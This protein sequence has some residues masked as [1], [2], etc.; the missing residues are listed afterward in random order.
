M[1]KAGTNGG[2]DENLRGVDL[3]F[4]NVKVIEFCNVAAGPYC[5]MLLADMGADVVKVESPAGDTLRQW[6]PIQD[7]MSANFVSLNRNKRSIALD[8]KRPEDLVVARRLIAGADIVLENNRPGAMARLGLGYDSFAADHPTLIYCSLSAYG[9]EGP[10]AN[11]G[12]FDVTVQAISG[13]MSVTGDLDGD[14]VKCGVPVSDF[15]TGLYGAFA[16][17]SLLARVRAGGRGGH[18]DVSML[19]SSLG[20]SALQTSEFFASGLNPRRMGA[21]HPRNA[22]YQA[23]KAS[24]GSFVL[25]A[26]ND[27]LWRAVCKVINR[28][29]L[30]DLPA[31]CTTT[32]RARNQTELATILNAIFAHR[33]IE[34]LISAFSGAGVP[35]TRV[36]SFEEALADPQVNHMGW[37]E[38]VALPS[39][40]KVTTFGSPIRIDGKAAPIRSG[41]PA[42]DGDREGVLRELDHLDAM[43]RHS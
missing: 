7:G 30:I 38:Q 18:I 9:Q 29:D 3:P 41:A 24:D 35:C 25:A 11:Q 16:V 10:R 26:G 42:L 34:D 31:F 19:G 8:L 1:Q 17:A 15:A 37:V 13:I 43:G 12:G 5:S 23:Y 21:A 33:R 6:P 32:D 2:E 22:P 20:I 4:R 28:E 39:A 36:N 14:P 40:Q 27:K